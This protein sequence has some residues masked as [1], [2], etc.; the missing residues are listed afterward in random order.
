MMSK[1]VL[2]SVTGKAQSPQEE[3]EAVRLLTTGTLTGEKDDWRLRYTETQPD[4]GGTHEI[5]VTMNRGVVTMERQGD[6]ETS[7]V[8]EKGCRFEGSYATP[9]GALDMGVYATRVKYQVDPSAG[10]EV[11]LQYQLDL[12]G[13]FAAMHEL[14]IR[15]CPA[16]KA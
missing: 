13:Q 15:F 6:Y 10:G 4:G 14:H 1:Q 5:T 8:F 9:Y 3:G 11:S 16:G 2:L 7:M 12:Q